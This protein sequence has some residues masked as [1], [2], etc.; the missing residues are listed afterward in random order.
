M[1]TAAKTQI[2]DL[3]KKISVSGSFDSALYARQVSKLADE[4]DLTKPTLTAEEEEQVLQKILD[5]RAVTSTISVKEAREIAT[6]EILNI[7]GS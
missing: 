4:V 6:R 1:P 5:L 7:R 3:L 2:D